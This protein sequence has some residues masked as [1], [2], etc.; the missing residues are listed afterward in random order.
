[1]VYH[2][3]DS[4]EEER[5][6]APEAFHAPRVPP[7]KANSLPGSQVASGSWPEANSAVTV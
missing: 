2:A 7:S 5:Q 3:P 4:G 6:E 1:M